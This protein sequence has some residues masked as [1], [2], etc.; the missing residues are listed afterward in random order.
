MTS[1]DL[2][3]A[4]Y[5][6]EEDVRDALDALET[7]RSTRRIRAGLADASR[8][9]DLYLNRS[10]GAFLPITETRYF[11]WPQGDYSRSWV[12]RLG[13]NTLAAPGAG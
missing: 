11:D 10:P 2:T 7:R 8:W 4:W 13:P 9:I 6:S 5:A 3:G 12:L 1:V